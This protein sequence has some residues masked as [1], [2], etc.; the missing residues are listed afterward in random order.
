MF[1]HPQLAIALS[2][3]LALTCA[4]GA[5][6]WNSP[7]HI[8]IAL[9]AYDQMDPATR[10]KA[11]EL[12]R[13]HPRF[14]EHFQSV[15]PREVARGDDRDKDQW[16]LAHAATWPD[17]VRDSKGGV[18]HQDVTQFNRPWWHFVNEPIF[19][20]DDERR[21]LQGE[22][23][24][25]RRRDPP[26]DSDEPN[27]NIIQALKNSSQIVRDKSAPNPKRA[28]HLCW[29]LH[30]VG[31]SHQ[32]LHSTA[33][34][35]TH[36]FRRGDHGGNYV[37]YEHNWNL[38]A[39]WDEQISSDEPFETLRILATDLDQNPKLQAAGREAATSLDP[40]KWI[41][42]SFDLAK[43]QGYTDE[44]LK[45]VADREGHSHLGTLD[46]SPKYKADAEEI[47]ERRA[48]QA[49][50]RLAATLDQLLQ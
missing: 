23:R 29:I 22:I 40:G 25:N 19:L 2:A 32:P 12:I 43:R 42:E 38:H 39:F 28:V 15:M 11:V 6:A 8:I 26:P 21:Q 37:D 3:V 1:R 34:F 14:N 45:K 27:M 30:L 36:R 7:G 10:T 4:Q 20:N 18:D 17:Q 24:V 5:S 48:I 31:D 9:I 50:Y 46:L 35:T 16:L 33:L 44:V 47:A 41:D 13:A 49:A